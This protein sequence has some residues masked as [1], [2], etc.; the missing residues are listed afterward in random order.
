MI[1]LK[2]GLILN[3]GADVI[4]NAEENATLKKRITVII[5]IAFLQKIF[6]FIFTLIF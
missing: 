2:F 3:D 5:T 4:L 6:P 1:I